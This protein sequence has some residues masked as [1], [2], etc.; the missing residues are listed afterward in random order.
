M[1]KDKNQKKT[2]WDVLCHKDD[3]AMPL[4]CNEGAY[5]INETA[6]KNILE[7]REETNKTY[8]QRNLHKVLQNLN[9]KWNWKLRI[10]N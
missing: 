9:N 4:I 2:K 10:E 5:K 1:S 6:W 7:Y 3:Y 8:K